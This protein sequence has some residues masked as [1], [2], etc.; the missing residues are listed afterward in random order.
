MKICLT[1]LLET[2]KDKKEILIQVL[3]A[4]D[5]RERT[6]MKRDKYINKLQS[7]LWDSCGEKLRIANY[8]VTKKCYKC[9]GVE[10]PSRFECI[11]QLISVGRPSGT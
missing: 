5:K 7:E 2:I 11:D 9:Q 4:V 8:I 1:P 3:A 10:C 6:I